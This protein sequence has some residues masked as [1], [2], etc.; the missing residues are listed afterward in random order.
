VTH[1]TQD[2]VIRA[3]AEPDFY[4]HRP[5]RVEHVQTHIS[6]VFLAGDYVYKLKKAVRFPF[7]DFSTL[8]RR[9]HFCAEELRLNRRLA[10]AIYLDVVPVVRTGAGRFA[11]GGDGELVEPVLRMRR[12]PAERMLPALL[13]ADAVDAAMMGRLARLLAA[14]HQRAPTGP[15]IAAHAAPAALRTR[16]DD[17][18]QALQPFVGSVLP[19]EE[20]ALLADFGPR[21]VR[22]HEPMLR[23]RQAG[24]YVRDGHGDLH[25]EHVCFVDEPAPAATAA[26]G[27]PPG[28][29]IFDCIEFSVPFRCNDVASEIAF[30]T[31][32]L[33]HRGRRDLAAALAVAYQD[34][35]ADPTIAALLPF[36][37]AV[38]ATIRATVACL[39]SAEDEVTASV[40]AAAA[41]EAAAY[42][43]LAMR[44]AWRAEGPAV[45]ACVGL[46]GSGKSTLAAALAEAM[47]FALVRSDVIRKRDDAPGA[48]TPAPTR[49]TAGARAA[50]YETLV[51]EV[52]AALAA[53]H[54]VIADATFLRRGDRARVAEVAARH[55]RPCI[56]VETTAP[57]ALVRARLAAR[58]AADVSDARWETYLTQ[59][60]AYEP[61]GPEE[62]RLVI[63]TDATPE[64]ARAAA[65]RALWEWHRVDD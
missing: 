35:A 50:V 52:D 4:P 37:A 17:T 64:A 2:E 31:M 39:T 58:T 14:F 7:L 46:S 16:W 1:G 11:L 6:H 65:L 30:L 23:A 60:Q 24:G 45:V 32:D 26:A 20:H 19:A 33:E 48:T 34:A 47:D 3:L 57:E 9:R 21:F 56:F 28:I 10:A 15:A 44:C 38:R 53:G 62:R 8:E 63:A 55:G 59:Q 43:R 18:L 40:R 13:A 5:P 36:Y 61:F 54:G 22:R 49:Y 12:L 42:L 29:Y 27:L 25:A 41:V 51:R